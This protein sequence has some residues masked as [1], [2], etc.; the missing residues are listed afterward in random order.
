MKN[1][2][3]KIQNPNLTLDYQAQFNPLYCNLY[4]A[5]YWYIKNKDV[6]YSASEIRKTKMYCTRHR[7]FAIQ[8]EVE[9]MEFNSKSHATF[10][11]CLIVSQ[12]YTIELRSVDCIGNFLAGVASNFR[13]K[14]I[15]YK[16][17]YSIYYRSPFINLRCCKC[18]I[19]SK[20]S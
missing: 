16:V 13:N 12:T 2:S 1:C 11:K 6:L 3:V 4:T 8:N 14:F 19:I 20:Y 5:W 18:I 10:H 15:E 9:N 7:K 17:R